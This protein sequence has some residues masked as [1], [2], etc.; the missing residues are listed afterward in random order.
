M[1]TMPT[2]LVCLAPLREFVAPDF[3][4]PPG[5]CDTHAHVIG[6]GVVFPFVENRSYTPPPATEQDYLAMLAACGMSRGVLVQVS[7]HGTDNRYMLQALS[8]HPDRLRGVC[9]IDSGIS[10]AELRA[11]HDAGVRGVRFN[12]LFG[13]GVGFDELERVA[14]RI[15]PLNWHV[16]ILMDVRDLPDLYPRMANLPVPRVIDHMGHMP[17]STGMQHAGFQALC[18]GVQ[19]QGW[20]VKLSG[21][22]RISEQD[23]Y[24]KVTPWAQHLI[25]IAP[26]RV[27]WG[28][29]WPH[30]GVAPMPDTVAMLNLLAK[31]AS[32]ESVRN[33]ILVDN[34]QRLYDFPPLST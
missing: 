4:P 22:Y 2:Q 9:V 25:E 33:R 34:P 11:M 32:D 26:D 21:A 14:A 12:V 29:D 5:A 10:D 17:V 31:W 16:Q 1:T 7:V 27:V 20:W 3:V 30:V 6:D 8:R 13:G 28:S 24:D 19:E 15:A 23:A 18:R